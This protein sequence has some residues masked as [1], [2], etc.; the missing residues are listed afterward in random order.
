MTAIEL[1]IL[2]PV[3]NEEDC[4]PIFFEKMD[5]FLKTAIVSSHVLLVND[6][7]SDKSLAIIQEKCRHHDRYQYISLDKNRGLSTAI[8]AGIDTCTTSYVGYIDVDLQTDPD[9]FNVLFSHMPTAALATGI[10]HKR[11]DTLV[12][13]MSSKIANFVRRNLVKDNITDSC[14]P[15]KILRT[16]IA[17]QLPFFNG[18]HRFIPALV[19]LKQGVVIEVPVRHYPRVAGTAKYHLFNRLIGPFFDMLAFCWMRKR[20]IVYGITSS[21]L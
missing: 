19:Q 3:F 1:T 6:G 8:K 12:K 9:D 18:M 4:L 7:S 5:A 14:C 13:K 16:D 21:S 2:A 11:K 10:R 20:N 15:L 17:K